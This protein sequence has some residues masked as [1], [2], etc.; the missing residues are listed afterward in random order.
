M[1]ILNTT[2]SIETGKVAE[3]LAYLREEYIPMYK[4]LENFSNEKIFE[5]YLPDGHQNALSL[6]FELPNMKAYLEWQERY[7]RVFERELYRRFGEDVLSFSTLLK[8][9][10]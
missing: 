1:V 4:E 6:Q 7:Q 9:I 10:D 3:F 8:T 2:F 5:I